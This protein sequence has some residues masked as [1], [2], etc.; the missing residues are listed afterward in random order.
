MLGGSKSPGM[1][2]EQGQ[3]L[4]SRGE[5]EGGGGDREND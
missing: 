2:S 3:K 4:T 5:K 1:E